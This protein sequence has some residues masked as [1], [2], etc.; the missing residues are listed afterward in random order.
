MD[1]TALYRP[2]LLR[3]SGIG[4]RF[5]ALVA[6]KAFDF[7]IPRH[8]IVSLIGPNGAGKT[9]FFNILTGMYRPDGGEIWFNGRNVCGLSA[10]QIAALGIARTFQNIRLFGNMTALE[11]VLVGEHCL[12]HSTVVDAILRTRATQ[13]E[14]G[15]A[16]NR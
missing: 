12:M 2:L 4:K 10:D 9:I 1:E 6:L 7:D 16:R 3:A 14:E 8:A 11:N 5:G 15:A 13:S